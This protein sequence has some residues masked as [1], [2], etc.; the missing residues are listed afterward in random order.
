MSYHLL[1]AEDNLDILSV[2]KLY[3]EASGHVV[4]FASNG[5]DALTIITQDKIDLAI[6][7]IMM[8]EINGYEL[9]RKIRANSNI[10]ILVISAKDQASDKI[11]GLTIGAD[12]YLA[13]PFNPMEVVA[14]VNSALRRF[15]QLGSGNSSVEPTTRQK[16][17]L[18]VFQLDFDKMILMKNGV[19][20]MLTPT[21]FRIM[22]KLMKSP[23]RVFA[24]AQLHESINGHYFESDDSSIM[25]HISNLREKIEVNPK[26]PRYIKTIRGVGYKF[27][28]DK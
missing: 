15:Y 25:V 23:G 11:L 27:E 10:P 8:P 24:K 12:D 13:K 19:Q 18:G 14:R 26:S 28:V 3:L 5:K 17:S 21:E 7:D 16:I 2:L 22:A 6:L 9:I 1:I 20:I 4:S